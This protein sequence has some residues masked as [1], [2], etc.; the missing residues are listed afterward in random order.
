MF[1]EKYR[2]LYDLRKRDECF[3]QLAYGHVLPHFFAAA[4]VNKEPRRE[5]LEKVMCYRLRHLSEFDTP[6]GWLP[7]AACAVYDISDRPYTSKACLNWAIR[8]LAY[9]MNPY[10]VYMYDP[11]AMTSLDTPQYGYKWYT[12]QHV[13]VYQITSRYTAEMKDFITME[14]LKQDVNGFSLAER[15]VRKVILLTTS[16][17]DSCLFPTY[18]LGIDHDLFKPLFVEAWQGRAHVWK[19]GRGNVIP[20]EQRVQTIDD[21]PIARPVAKRKA[22]KKKK[23]TQVGTPDDSRRRKGA[24]FDG[25]GLLAE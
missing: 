19:D 6:Q 7:E 22:G 8:T 10:D 5:A 23:T 2:K 13:I 9:V 12:G 18:N 17:N 11:L 20:N 25:F 24:N 15:D 4:M 14:I 3:L 1:H 21:T 16:W